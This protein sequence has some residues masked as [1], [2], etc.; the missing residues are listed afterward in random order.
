MSDGTSFHLG[1]TVPIGALNPEHVSV[2]QL[3]KLLRGVLTHEGRPDKGEGSYQL[4]ECEGDFG[5]GYALCEQISGDGAL[6][7]MTSVLG[8]GEMFAYLIGR[9]DA[10]RNLM[11][12]LLE[13]L[14]HGHMA[15]KLMDEF[16]SS[17]N[18][19]REKAREEEDMAGY[20][21]WIK[22]DD[23]TLN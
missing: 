18:K 9:M 12:W 14:G 3:S 16:T 5:S 17:L 23:E 20:G 2:E 21:P 4:I 6:K 13:E 10:S 11:V 1:D 15:K 7:P 19:K 8:M 22:C